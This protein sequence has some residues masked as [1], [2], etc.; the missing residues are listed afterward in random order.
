[1]TTSQAVIDFILNQRKKGKKPPT[2]KKGNKPTA[3]RKRAVFERDGDGN[4][5]G[6]SFERQEAD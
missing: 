1:M 2:P 3:S 4:L 6:M 5:I